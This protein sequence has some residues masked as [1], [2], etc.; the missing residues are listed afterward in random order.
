MIFMYCSLVCV[1]VCDIHV[2]FTSPCVC[3]C[4]IHV[5]FTS[6]CVCV[7]VC[8][9]FMY[10][11]LVRVCVRVRVCVFQKAFSLSKEI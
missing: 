9:I 1:C 11:S 3:V 5:F 10:S 7:C 8:E 6:P 2:L 4:D